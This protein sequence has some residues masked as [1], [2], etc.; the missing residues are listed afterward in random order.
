MAQKPDPK[1][2]HAREHVHIHAQHYEQDKGGGRIW[3]IGGIGLLI[4]AVIY[5]AVLVIHSRQ[6]ASNATTLELVQLQF[7]PSRDALGVSAGPADAQVTVREFADFQCPAC[8][9]FEP[10]LEQM[11]KDYVD[12]GKVRFI[13]FDFPLEDLHKNA[14]MASQ[15]ARCAGNQDHYWQMHDMLYSKQAEWGDM[16]DPMNT[17]LGYGDK[18]GLDGNKM[19]TC[20]RTGATHQAVLSSEAYG[21]A[22]S[23]HSTPTFAVNDQANVGGASY[24]DLKALIDEQLA[25]P[26]H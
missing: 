22:L 7:D 4:V 15:F 6:R 1:H 11:R 9:G 8:G 18:L 2:E 23:M 14:V 10:V 5:S 19:L 17:L 20:I 25:A 13:F 12:T 21:D 26:K 3:L 24:A 16:K